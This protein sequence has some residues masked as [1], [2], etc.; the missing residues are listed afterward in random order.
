MTGERMKVFRATRKKQGMP[1]TGESP[2]GFRIVGPKGKRRYEPFPEQRTLGRRMLSWRNQTKPW[3][4]EQIMRH[5][6][7]NGV[8]HPETGRPFS[9]MTVHR[10]CQWEQELQEREAKGEGKLPLPV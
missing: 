10:W 2:Y 5:L 9:I 8:V 1:H 3:S 4:Y 7:D 6:R